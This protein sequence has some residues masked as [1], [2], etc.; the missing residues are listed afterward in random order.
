MEQILV[1]QNKHWKNEK[2]TDVFQ[3]KITV[4]AENPLIQ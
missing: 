4:N 1:N 2:Y 3:R